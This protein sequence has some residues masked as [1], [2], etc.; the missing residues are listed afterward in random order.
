MLISTFSVNF[1]E[2]R[3]WL[4]LAS[5]LGF[6]ALAQTAVG[7]WRPAWLDRL[8][9]VGLVSLGLFLLLCVS[10]VTFVIFLV[11]ALGS[12]VGLKWVLGRPKEGQVRYLWVLIP[13][14]LLPLLYYKY[15]NF[16]ANEVLDLNLDSLRQLAI[17]VGISFYTFQKVA[18]V[19]D[20]LAFE[21]PLPRFLDYLNFAGFFPQIVAGPIERRRDLLPQMEQFRFAWN[22]ANINDGVSW[23]VVGLFFKCCLADNLAN[24]FN[25]SLATNAFVI[26]TDNVLFGL[27]IYYDF[28]GYSLIAL[29]LARCL[30][31]KLTLNFLSPYWSTSISEFWRRWHISFS[32]WILDYIFMPLQMQWRDWPRPKLAAA[33]ALLVTF[34]VSGLWHGAGWNFVIWGA[35]H[36]TY[37]IVNRFC[38]TKHR[39]PKRVAWL[40]TWVAVF[41]AWLSFYELRT[42]VLLTKMKTIFTPSAYSLGSLRA[43][44]GQW[45]PPDRAVLLCFVGLTAGTLL[46]EWLSVARQGEPYCFLRRPWVLSVLIILTFLLAPGQNNAFIYFAF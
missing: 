16:A 24:Y 4:L 13:L 11:V 31:I 22:P 17:P 10:W 33:L 25:G 36:G 20:T 38:F 39:L 26:W 42:G 19:V 12:Y 35:L 15:A 32:R 40:I 5:G 34:L 7:R 45:S 43:L 37:L 44:P 27:R 41:G 21:Q 46:L 8:D 29:G 14:Q 23:I 28:A 3:F 1:A 30:G 9:K 6:I 2:I 18:F